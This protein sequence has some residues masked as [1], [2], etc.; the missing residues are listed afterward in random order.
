[1]RGRA[2][3]KMPE[4]MV[5]RKVMPAR[6]MMIVADLSLEIRP[7]LWPVCVERALTVTGACSAS[8]CAC[9]FLSTRPSMMLAAATEGLV[10]ATHDSSSVSS[11]AAAVGP[12]PGAPGKDS[13][14]C[15]TCFIPNLLNL[16]TKGGTGFQR[17]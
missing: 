16:N 4:P 13:E 17:L 11:C 6:V 5:F 10:G 1:M 8:S 9:F 14:T 2:L 3:I 12:V 7:G 15:L